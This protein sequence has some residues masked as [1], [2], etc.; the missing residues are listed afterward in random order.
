[1]VI[2]KTLSIINLIWALKALTAFAAPKSL[3]RSD[4]CSYRW[5]TLQ[6]FGSIFGW[7]VYILILAYAQPLHTKSLGWW[8]FIAYMLG[9]HS[10]AATGS[11]NNEKLLTTDMAFWYLNEMS[12]EVFELWDVILIWA[13]CTSR[14]VE[15]RTM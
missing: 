7:R 8:L 4:F 13:T 9:N 12:Y 11:W 2:W 15:L 10:P 1:M 6:D 14:K 3:S 5:T